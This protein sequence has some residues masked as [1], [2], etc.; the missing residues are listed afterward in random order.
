MLKAW[1]GAA[2]LFTGVGCGGTASASVQSE[3][4]SRCMV[5]RTNPADRTHL[6]QWIFAA[7][8][9]SP[10]VR[11]MTTMTDA[12]RETY[13]RTGAELL[14]RL[15]VSDCHAETVAAI[16]SDGVGVLQTSFGAL[17]QSAMRDLMTDPTVIVAMA[18]M[19]RYIDIVAMTK[20]M[21]EAGVTPGLP[22]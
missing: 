4:L 17:G 11:G 18:Q 15:L 19:T 3:A 13:I 14:N 9:A 6:V 5:A 21:L 1:I 20:L 16:K 8:S 2:A 7:I 22:R 10:S 12:Q